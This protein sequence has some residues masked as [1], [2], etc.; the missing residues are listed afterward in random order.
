MKMTVDTDF[1][2][3]L[4]MIKKKAGVITTDR[5]IKYSYCKGQFNGVG[6]KKGTRTF[7]DCYVSDNFQ[8]F[9]FEYGS[10][11]VSVF[12]EQHKWYNTKIQVAEIQQPC[13]RGAYRFPLHKIDFIESNLRRNKIIKK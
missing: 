1:L 12:E 8:S 7:R 3:I 9:T 5:K 10:Y 6:F 13:R 11:F 4:Q 2:E